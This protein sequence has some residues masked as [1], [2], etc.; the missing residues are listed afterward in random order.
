MPVPASTFRLYAFAAMAALLLTSGPV[1]ADGGSLAGL[2]VGNNA[3]GRLEVFQVDGSGELRHRWQRE[4]TRD[5]SSWSSLGGDFSPGISVLSDST[6]RLVIFALNRAA[7]AVEYTFQKEPNSPGWSSWTILPSAHKYGSV[8]A[9]KDAAGRF[10]VFV[11]TSDTHST[12]WTRQVGDQDQWSDWTPIG[13]HLEPGI[14]VARNAAG[15]IEAFGIDARDGMLVHCRQSGPDEWTHWTSLGEQV[16][17]G[18]AVGENADGRLEV[19]GVRHSDNCVG[20]S[21]EISPAPETAWSGW[22]N[23]GVKMKP[24]IAL[25]RNPDGRIEVFTVNPD[26]NM[27]FHTFQVRGHPTNWVGWTDMSLVGDSLEGRRRAGTSRRSLT[28]IGAITS[29]YPVVATNAQ[30][31]LELFAFDLGPERILNNRAQITGNMLWCDWASMDR[32]ASQYISRTWRIDDGLPDN[33]VQAITQTPDGYIWVG[34]HNGLAR[35]DGTHFTLCGP[36]DEL[37]TT[38]RCVSSL[39]VDSKGALWIGFDG[40]GLTRSFDGVMSHYDSRT[41]LAGDSVTAMCERLDGSL[42][43]GSTSGLSCFDH[44]RFV[45]FTTKNGLLSDDVRAVLEDSNTNLWITTDKGLNSISNATITAFTG[46]NGLPDNSL[47]GIWQDVPGRLWIGSSR[48]MILRRNRLYYAYDERFALSD[49]FVNVIRNDSDGDLWLGTDTGLS[50]FQEGH[51]SDEMNSEG[52]AFGRVASLFEDREGN[53]WIGSE[54]GLSRLAR[55]GLLVY[56]TKQGLSHNNITSIVEDD[57]GSLW[58]GN[59]AGLD[60]LNGDAITAYSA[61]KGFPIESV[62]CL[63]KG[64]DGSIWAGGDDGMGVVQIK[65]GA[66]TSYTPRA[67]LADGKVMVQCEDQFSNV[68]VGTSAGLSCISN[69]QFITNDAVVKLSGQSVRALCDDKQGGIWIGTQNGLFHWRKGQMETFS[70]ASALSDNV[71]T[72]LFQDDEQTLWIG[73]ETGGLIRDGK[74]SFTKY[75]AENGLFSNEI[76]DILED[77]FNW[78]WMS[79][80]RGIF[81]VLKSNLEAL[82]DRRLKR[83]ASI[84][85]GRND[86]MAS[87]LCS[88]GKPGAWKTRDGRLWFATSAGV[89]A[90]DPR[91]IHVNKALP[92]AYIEQIVLDGKPLSPP[93]GSATD[94]ATEAVIRIPPGHRELEV[95]YTALGIP[96]PERIRFRYKLEGGDSDW[97]DAETRRVAYYDNLPPGPYNFKVTACNNDGMWSPEVASLSIVLL[98]HFWE[99]WWFRL[100]AVSGCVGIVAVAARHATKTKMQRKME[101]L[102]QQHAVEKERM[103]IARDIHDDLGGSL[104]QITFLGEM[105]KRDLGRPAEAAAHVN[106]LTNS[107]RQT[108]RALDEIVWAVRPENDRLDHLTLYL[109][110]FA[111]EFFGPTP[112]RC[113][114]EF[115]PDV[116]ARFVS[117]DV[118]HGI[119]L[120]VK[121]AFNN[122]LKHSE[123]NEVRLRCDFIDET[124][125][126]AIEDNGKGFNPQP[127][128]LFQNGL[129]NMKKRVE[130]FDGEFLIASEAGRGTTLKFSIPIRNGQLH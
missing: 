60:Q 6:G 20:H 102:E 77:D 108:V 61:S 29:S 96:T 87:V 83:I 68:W 128:A 37:G 5:W 88:T 81:R 99:T 9:T 2:A 33:R 70:S 32:S 12:E 53:L 78:L 51:F 127:A 44:G 72:A 86:G 54:N 117:A 11:V 91:A 94:F 89:V 10:Q 74:G 18:F 15:F 79:S 35:F 90:I 93:G 62:S 39:F 56:G 100:L 113:R 38:N 57:N 125:F 16:L 80:S 124:L 123:A 34:T 50:R 28:D 48:G 8:A 22:A 65:D 85:Y 130:E 64:R 31:S 109:W 4:F 49:K 106:K 27:I 120:V 69:R 103:R 67:G 111:E 104:T 116:P 82:D 46:K 45:N 25:E 13:G 92:T 76:F 112:V 7:H 19:V 84:V 114:V 52:V 41:G 101:L 110:Q 14:A 26:D 59:R 118:R 30:G 1:R 107:A 75:T 3:D 23:F 97:V 55:K 71:I 129:G 17:P 36:S 63:C 73:T 24:G 58:L 126:V 66:L 121:E 47:N 40:G 95:H 119:Y 42:W 105:T 98:P 21:Y 122:T 115:P 43:I